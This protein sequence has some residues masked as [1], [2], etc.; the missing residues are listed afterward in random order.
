LIS[1]PSPTRPL[2]PA[3][4]PPDAPKLRF[5]RGRRF[6]RAIV[7]FGA[8]SFWGHLWHLAASVIATEDIDS[9]DWMIADDPEDLTRHIAEEL[10]GHPHAPSLTAALEDDLWI[11]FIADTG[12]CSS[13]SHAVAR[14]LFAE[15]EVSAPDGSD[16]P[17]ILPRGQ[18]LVFGG[19]TAY[20]VATE[21]EIHNRVIVPFNQ[22]LRKAHDGKR[23]VLLGVP[24]NHDWYAGLDGFGRMFRRRHGSVDRT[25]RVGTDQIDRGGQI[26]HFIQ[27]VEAFRVGRF[28][29]KR[30]ILP[31]EGYTPVQRASYW[32]L[33]LAPGLD[34]WGPDRQLRALDFQQQTY[35]AGAEG[36]HQAGIILVLA[37]PVH[38]FL[39]PSRAGQ[40][41]LSALN[42]SLENDKLL[43][44]SGDTHHYCRQHIGGGVHITAGGGGAF[45]HPARIA[46]TGKTP[47]EAEFPG[48]VASLALA[49]QIPLQIA[50]GRS[51]FLVHAAI[52]ILYGPAFGIELTGGPESLPVAATTSLVS[53]V[54]CFLLAGV[55]SGKAARIAAL[56]ALTGL[57]LGFLPF[58]L[59]RLGAVLLPRLGLHPATAPGLEILFV[60]TVY[61]GTIAFGAFLTAL[62]ILGLEQHQAFGALAHPGYKHFV[63]LRVRRDGT[64]VD[65][66]VL[67]RV[68]PL[69]Q[70]DHVVLV[71]HFT[72]QNP[73]PMGGPSSRAPRS[74]AK[75]S[76]PGAPGAP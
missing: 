38:A 8:R 45:L 39:E 14:M 69:G 34:L 6:P 68:D 13:L 31:L 37:D 55:H 22:I 71:D 3:P 56:A 54:L 17:L 42:L 21:L 65:G 74:R 47:P 23:R 10:G 9:R 2:R 60:L 40:E 62:T 49:L 72:W 48:P 11:D 70:K 41:I 12:D 32:A 15:Y 43:I 29:G 16:A 52:A 76:P 7:W 24:G 58:G 59:Q 64:Q 1:P 19:D 67:G 57:V 53:A 27:W 30:S 33:H 61:A 20:P 66:W 25:S 44:L 36:E 5:R 63:R 35:F 46:R 75:V 50:H 26:G 51:G 18:L 28:V 73:S 4:C